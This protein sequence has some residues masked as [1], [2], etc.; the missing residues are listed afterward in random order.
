MQIPAVTWTPITSPAQ[1]IYRPEAYGAVG[2]GS[3]DDTAAIQDAIDA[4]AAAGSGATVR[5][6]QAYAYTKTADKTD[7]G[8]YD[9]TYGLWLNT[10]GITIDGNDTGSLVMTADPAATYP[11]VGLLV[12]NGGFTGAWPAGGWDWLE[13]NGTWVED[14]VIKDLSFDNSALADADLLAMTTGSLSSVLALAFCKNCTISG[15]TIDRAWG[16][17]GGITSHCSS[18]GSTVTDCTITLTYQRGYHFDGNEGGTFTSL[19]VGGFVATSN[20]SGI[21]LATNT[22]YRHDSAN[23]T[24]SGCTLSGIHIGI[25]A[26]G[27]GHTIS[28]NTVNLKD[29]SVTHIGIELGIGDTALFA[30]NSGSH[31]VTGNIIAKATEKKGYG[32]RTSG[33]TATTYDG[34]PRTVSS[35]SMTGNTI[36]NMDYGYVI[37][38]RSINNTFTGNTLTG[39][40]TVAIDASDGSASGNVT[41]PNP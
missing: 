8:A 2:D 36:S 17:T 13:V 20:E 40:T 24:I 32:I 23:C 37:E 25:G 21:A 18:Q 28:S 41:S 33:K 12:G 6:D 16:A 31:S 39:V 26:N 19:T 7:L 3:T 14:C 30:A 22:D 1:G 29:D 10:S 9:I 35:C 4:A 15:I 27:T 38:D 34:Q 11:F 5:L